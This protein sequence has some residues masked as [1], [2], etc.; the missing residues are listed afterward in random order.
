MFD[1]IY[2]IEPWRRELI[3]ENLSEN[4]KAKYDTAIVEF[5]IKHME[6]LLKARKKSLLNPL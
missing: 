3:E 5:M 6:E 2:K 1:T 4:G